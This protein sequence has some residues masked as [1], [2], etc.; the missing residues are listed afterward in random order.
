MYWNVKMAECK[1]QMQLAGSKKTPI[2]NPAFVFKG[3]GRKKVTVKV[4]GEEFEEG[5][6]YRAGYEKK[7]RR[8]RFGFM[9]QR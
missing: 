3:W 2:V 5:K 1:V 8:C 9:V 4:S 7:I 6:N